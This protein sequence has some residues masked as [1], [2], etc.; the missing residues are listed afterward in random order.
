LD[1]AI[2]KPKFPMGVGRRSAVIGQFSMLNPAR[3]HNALGR[4]VGR[5]LAFDNPAFVC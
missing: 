3:I 5:I 2:G 1:K 4:N